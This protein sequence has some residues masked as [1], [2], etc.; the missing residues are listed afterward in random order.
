MTGRSTQVSDDLS[1]S[2][3]DSLEPYRQAISEKWRECVRE[4]YGDDERA[5]LFPFGGNDG[6][7]LLSI[8]CNLSDSKR[9]P[10]D[11]QIELIRSHLRTKDYSITDFFKEHANLQATLE[12]CA[13]EGEHEPSQKA[14]AYIAGLLKALNSLSHAV[15]H[16]TAEFLE[17]VIEDCNTGF[18]QTDL[19]G[20]IVY[21]NDELQRIAGR[22]RLE[23][24]S[25]DSLFEAHE[26]HGIRQVFTGKSKQKTINQQLHLTNEQG[27]G[28]PVGVE[29]SVLRIFGEPVGAY[30]FITNLSRPIRLQNEIYDRFLLGI[31]RLDLYQ[32]MTYTNKSIRDMLG[33]EGNSWKGAKIDTLV[34]KE[35]LPIIRSQLKKRWEGQSDEYEIRFLRQDDQRPVPVRISASPKKDLQGNVIGTM[36]IIRSIVGEKMHESI[37]SLRNANDLLNAVSELLRAAVPFDRLSVAIF[38]KNKQHV[39]NF[40]T[41]S[42]NGFSVS[43]KRWWEMSPTMLLWSKRRSIVS[44]SDLKAFYDKPEFRHL[45][46]DKTIKKLL[47]EFTSFIY[48]PIFKKNDL[49]ACVALYSASANPYSR[50]HCKQLKQLPVDTA[51]LS[52]LSFEE[53][54]RLLFLL[55]LLKEISSKGSEVQKTAQIIVTRI[56]QHFEWESVALFRVNRMRRKISLLSQSNLSADFRVPDGFEQSIGEGIL[57]EAY[58]R[59]ETIL[60]GDVKRGKYKAK[61]KKTV[62]KTRSELCMPIVSGDLCWLLNI[63][64]PR[65][66]AFSEDEKDALKMVV[67]EIKVFMERT[68]LRSFLDKALI[69]TSDAVLVVDDDGRITLSNAAAQRML[70]YEENELETKT[71]ADLLLETNMSEDLIQ[72]SKMPNVRV[73]MRTKQGQEIHLLLSKFQLH[74]EIS[75]NIIVAKDLSLE[76]RVQ[77]LEYIGKLYYEIAIQTKPPLTLAFSWLRKAGRETKNP[78]IREL[79]EK[80]LQQVRK[81][82]LTF[83]RLAMYDQSNTNSPDF[84]YNEMLLEFDEVWNNLQE[85]FPEA[86]MKRI[87]RTSSGP[88]RYLR[89]DPF[90]ITFCLETIYSYLLR[91]LPDD[92]VVHTDLTYHEDWLRVS[93]RGYFPGKPAA[94]DQTNDARAITQTLMDIALGER[95]IQSFIEKCGGVYH[96]HRR[97]GN[98][99]EFVFE[100]PTEAQT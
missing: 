93:V 14:K 85:T 69:S 4:T 47:Q 6:S 13:R 57:G 53:N 23:G 58:A 61:Y 92:D 29:L 18:C 99:I 65:T 100:L 91:F 33:I 60:L 89:G 90:F 19:K 15:L 27:E 11:E 55:E 77:E 51:V 66:N 10:S 83:N 20:R 75:A 9:P 64:D 74:E 5:D 86:E 78:L 21:A 44:V 71:L 46:Q 34:L 22:V 98:R 94:T 62:T 49:V 48:Y 52:A 70:G 26:R 36:G 82:D 84:P 43:N 95:L 12:R 88:P 72:A 50:V 24:S 87:R 73:K 67:D 81:M 63:E 59:Q 30:A 39:R 31:I 76:D 41:Y 3:S 40:F 79:T 42:P 68:W 35:D 32:R 8:V 2:F 37:E 96:P 17:N 16:G 25:L 38:S 45:K 7:D 97:K 28:V 80:T 56:A 1:S 54:D